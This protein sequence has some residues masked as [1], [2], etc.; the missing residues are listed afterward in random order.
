MM[1]VLTQIVVWLNSLAN[2]VGKW[3]LAPIAALPGWL[4]AT[5]VAVLTGVLLLLAFKYTSNQRAIKRARD[6]INANLLALKL[7]KE[8]SAVALQAQG[9][10][11]L[12]A[13]RLSVLA[14]VPI[15]VMAVPVTLILGQLSLW[16]QQRPLAIENETTKEAIVTMALEGDDGASFPEVE[17]QP[18]GAF[19]I[20]AGPVRV[21]SKREIWWKIS[22]REKG[23]HLLTFRVGDQ[24]ID[25]ELA[26]GDGFMRVSAQRPGW[27]WM[28]ALEHP[29]ESP[30]PPDSP[31]RSIKIDY[32]KRSSWTSGTNWWLAYWFGVSMISGLCFRRV[33]NVNL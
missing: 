2:A 22:A 23:Y 25:K 17:L 24:F 1:D 33:L 16:Y 26:I 10:V 6:A 3:T 20:I 12:G 13:A 29:K 8:S 19:E 7:F 15:L 5:L 18:S 27:S 21:T 28:D 31:V 14:L 11:L 4:S 30:L 32:P 9:R